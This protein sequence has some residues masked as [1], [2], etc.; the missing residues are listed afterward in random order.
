MR[1]IRIVLVAVLATAGCGGQQATPRPTVE[2]VCAP[3]P[4]QGPDPRRLQCGEA[5]AAAIDVARGRL[6]GALVRVRFVW[7]SY[8]PPGA[9]C[10]VPPPE[11]GVVFFTVEGAP[12]ES[13]VEL[14]KSAV[15]VRVV[16]GPTLAK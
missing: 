11:L 10:L 16:S 5:I 13:Y 2:V 6:P 7:G 1:V 8:C 4:F 12:M 14:E 9:R 15:G 3:D